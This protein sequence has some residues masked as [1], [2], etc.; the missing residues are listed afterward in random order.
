MIRIQGLTKTFGDLLAVDDLHLEVPA[1]ELFG[2][3]GPNGAGK[4]TT[5]RML[6]SLLRPTAGDA[7]VNGFHV[8]HDAMEVK[9]SIGYLPENPF[10]YDK[11]TGREFLHFIAGLHRVPEPTRTHQIDRLLELFGLTE[12]AD[13]LIESYS[14][15]MRKKLALCSVLVHR[16]KV[17][18]LD[19]PTNSLDP[20]SARLVKDILRELCRQGTTVFMSTHIL[21]IA[22]QMCERVGIIHQGRLVAVGS[23][24]ELRAGGGRADAS[25][26]ELFIALT[27]GPEVAEIAAY[28]REG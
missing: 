21:E 28:L 11:L 4:T 20:R 2:F 26:E 15:G 8:V 25:L 1:G 24:E 17:L 22:E 14:Q 10:L 16:P 18:F 12:R 7:W 19:E 13:D 3:L 27:G 9:R 23:L 5:I 6:T